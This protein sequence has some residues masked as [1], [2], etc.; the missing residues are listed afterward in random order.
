M[1]ANCKVWLSELL[2]GADCANTQSSKNCLFKE[3][4]TFKLLPLEEVMWL[5][6]A[7]ALHSEREYKAKECQVTGKRG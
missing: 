6:T 4:P 2:L 7:A 1:S 5:A 3:F